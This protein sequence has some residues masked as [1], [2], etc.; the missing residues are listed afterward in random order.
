MD[1]DFC[2]RMDPSHSPSSW[3]DFAELE[4]SR[5]F[6]VVVAMG[7]IAPGHL[8]LVANEHTPSMASVPTAHQAEL[9]DLTKTWAARLRAR[10]GGEVVVF[11]HGSVGIDATSGA[12]IIHAHWQ[13]VP[14]PAGRAAPPED[15]VPIRWNVHVSDLANREYLLMEH[16][17]G[18]YVSPPGWAAAQPQFWRR[19][20]LRVVGRPDE[21]DYLAYPNLRDMAIT[22]QAL[23]PGGAIPRGVGG[24]C[25]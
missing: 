20:L 25:A 15:F 10:F 16:E 11:E 24:E 2:I 22:L 5:N 17:A 23:S 19:R 9:R 7:S 12:C 4:S 21:W 14:M 1:C 3:Y 18:S 13:I 6:R 8:L